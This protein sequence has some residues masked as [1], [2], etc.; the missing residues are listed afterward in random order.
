M[1]LSFVRRHR[2]DRGGG[3]VAEMAPPAAPPPFLVAQRA[4]RTAQVAARLRAGVGN[5]CAEGFVALL[6]PGCPTGTMPSGSFHPR[7]ARRQRRSV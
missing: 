4:S 3:T 6:D 1:D 7:V 2:P 5:V